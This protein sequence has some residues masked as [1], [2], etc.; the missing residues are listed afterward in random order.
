[1]N[2][3]FNLYIGLICIVCVLFHL[4]NGI[5]NGFRTTIKYNLGITSILIVVN[6]WIFFKKSRSGDRESR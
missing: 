6:F 3:K 4:I 2:R 5:N 1:M